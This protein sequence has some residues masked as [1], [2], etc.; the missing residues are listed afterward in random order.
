MSE[1]P[2]QDLYDRLYRGNPSLVKTRDFE[3]VDVRTN[4]LIFAFLVL[5]NLYQF[6]IA[7]LLLSITPWFML[8][9]LPTL[10]FSS[11]TGVMVHEAIHGLLH[12]DARRNR[13]MGQVMAVF[14][15]IAYDLQRFDHLRHHR[16]SRTENDCD[17]I[18]IAPHPSRRRVLNYYYR[19][20]FGAYWHDF[21]LSAVVCFLP[22]RFIFPIMSF[23]YGSTIEQADHS[24]LSITLRNKKLSALRTEG[25][26]ILLLLGCSAYLYDGNLWVLVVLYLLRALILTVLD[27]FAHYQTPIND[28]LFARNVK[29]PIFFERVCL[30]NFNYHGAH[31]I[32]PTVPWRKI[33]QYMHLF[34][35][36]F[37]LIT[38]GSLLRSLKAKYKPPR[39]FSVWPNGWLAGGRKEKEGCS[40]PTGLS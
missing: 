24:A 27:S 33:P 35:P 23:I 38:H 29:V 34:E 16:I 19:K 14:M 2:P 7:P 32:F 22:I 8:T 13:R 25:A 37:C 28:S 17:E 1:V 39:A 10:L 18:Y 4:N 5:V 20:L 30:M 26:C 12:S 6:F 36:D 3:D 15:G 40:N 21:V 11:T 31:H 9:L